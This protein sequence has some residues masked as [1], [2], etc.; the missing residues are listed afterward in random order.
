MIDPGSAWPRRALVVAPH[1]DDEVLGAGGLIAVLRARGCEVRVLYATVSGYRSAHR[2]DHP[3]DHERMDEAR[4]AMGVLG[5]TDLQVLYTGESHHLR[6]DTVPQA[7]IIA[8]IERQ[9]N[10]FAPGVVVIPC[11]GHYNQDHRAVGDACVAALRPAPPGRKHFAPLVLAYGHSAGGWGGPD[12]AFSPTVFVDITAAIDT[13]LQALACYESQ[14]IEPPHPRS[15]DGVRSNSA[16]WGAYAGCAY[17]EPYE[18]LRAV[19]AASPT[20]SDS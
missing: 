15:L 12:R 17:A 6:L 7:E 8:W 5:V 19:V 4:A 16:A 13:K 9:A 11:R 3:P 20:S 2:G 10:E 14:L 1:A 18:C